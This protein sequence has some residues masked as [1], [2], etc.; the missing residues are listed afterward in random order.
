VFHKEDLV[1]LVD[2][3]DLESDLTNRNQ[4]LALFIGLPGYPE[5]SL[6]NLDLIRTLSHKYDF[7][8]VCVDTIGFF[9]NHD[10]FTHVDIA[11]ASL[12]GFFSGKCNVSGGWYD[13]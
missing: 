5:L 7:P 4:L 10:L 9:S 2:L 12:G 1:P 3:R 13:S 8:V 11:V 6:E